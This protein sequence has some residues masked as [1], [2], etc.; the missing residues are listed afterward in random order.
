MGFVF[1]TT[2]ALMI[3]SLFSGLVS[4]KPISNDWN[5]DTL[6]WGLNVLANN[7]ITTNPQYLNNPLRN[8]TQT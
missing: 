1:D 3:Y 8:P 6:E 5:K 4:I 7:Y 2:I